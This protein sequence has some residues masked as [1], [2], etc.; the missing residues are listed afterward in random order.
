[1]TLQ[2]DL[3]QAVARVTQDSQTL[4]EIVHGDEQTVVLTEG[5]D[6]SSPAKVIFDIEQQIQHQLTDLNITL[7][8]LQD[9]VAEAQGYAD[10][11]EH[12]AQTATTAANSTNFPADL[13][14]GAGKLLAVNDEESGYTLTQTSSTVYGLSKAGAKLKLHINEDRCNANTFLSYFIAPV[15]IAIEIDT[16]GHLL[17]TV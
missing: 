1:M 12:Q 4:H 2:Q 10:N 17:V 11:A 5:G 6:V 9:A 16:R 7:N 15:G 3:E 8:A 13:T 14:E